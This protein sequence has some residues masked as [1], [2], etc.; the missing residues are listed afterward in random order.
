M[1]RC[2]LDVASFGGIEGNS[3]K[4]VLF[5]LIIYLGSN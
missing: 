5:E 2:P 1:I 3:K 4:P